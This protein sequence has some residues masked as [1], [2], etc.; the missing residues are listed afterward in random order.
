MKM[1]LIFSDG[2]ADFR[3]P[4]HYKWNPE[5]DSSRAD[6]SEAILNMF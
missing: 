2:P 1:Q 4:Q 3:F 6:R 5:S